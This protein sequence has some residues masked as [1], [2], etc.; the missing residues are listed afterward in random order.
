MLR[1]LALLAL[2]VL[3]PLVGA[4]PAAAATASPASG[5]T[6][7]DHEQPTCE[8]TVR[9]DA[10][11][12]DNDTVTALDNGSETSVRSNTEVT[13]DT[14]VA[15]VQLDARNP[16]GYCVRY[17]V[18]ISPD[19]VTAAELG[20]IDAAEGEQT[21]EWQAI[22]DFEADETYTE[23]SFVLGAG[24]N[25]T[26]APS[27]LRVRSL[28]WTGEVTN[29]TSGVLPNFDLGSLLGGDL[30]QREYTFEAPNDSDSV[31]V[32]LTNASTGKTVDEYRAL[33]RTGDG[34][35]NP[36]TTDSTAPVYKDERDDVVTFHFD[37]DSAE[38]RF[39]ANPGPIDKARHQWHAYTAGWDGIRDMIPGL[40]NAVV[41]LGVAVPARRR[42]HS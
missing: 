17:V 42:V 35:W 38:V 29:K 25:A 3:A 9:H 11:R 31:P 18:E 19:V 14:N 32:S 1:T 6:T 16:N 34:D 28:K 30:E 24:E 22:H 10:F 27:Q 36:V 4:V 37:D 8:T 23:V 26:F 21:A 39:T 7:F 15:F 13:L 12:H 33:Y 40:S 5:A 2:V 20:H 41:G